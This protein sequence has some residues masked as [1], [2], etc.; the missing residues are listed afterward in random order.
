[1]ILFTL[2]GVSWLLAG[3]TAPPRVLLPDEQHAIDRK[4]VEY[5]GGYELRRFATG[6]TAPTCEAF[7]ADGSLL[8]AQGERGDEP[9]IWRFPRSG[10]APVLV[11]PRKPKFPFY[12][13]RGGWRMYGPIGGMVVADGKIIV[14]HRDEHDQGVV[15]ELDSAGNHTTLVAGMPAQGEYG[16]TDLAINPVTGDLWFG[17]GTYTNSGVVG[18]DDWAMRWVRDHPELH[19]V[20][21]HDIELLGYKFQTPNP[22]AG[23]FGPADLAV[24]AAFQAFSQS[25]AIRIPGSPDGRP[26]GAIYSVPR[27]G[28]FPQVQGHGI[29]NPSGIVFN[30]YAQAYFTNQGMEMR[31]TRPIKNDPC[32]LL[33]L[34]LDGN[35][36]FGWPDYTADLRSVGEPLYQPPEWMISRSGYPQVRPLIDQRASGLE[37]PRRDALLEAAFPSLSGAGKLAFYRGPNREYRDNLIVVL[38]GDRTPFASG[39][40]VLPRREGFKVVR[41]DLARHVTADFVRNVHDL[42]GSSIGHNPDLIERPFDV[43]F[44]PDGA[45]YILDEGRMQM[46]DGR[47]HFDKG[48]GQIFRLVPV[49][50]AATQGK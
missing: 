19:D 27:H 25:F 46:K 16:L 1:M 37:A 8:I 2:F 33:R 26:S 49:R 24:T 32:A 12:L 13:A 39:G 29:H 7:D 9:Q 18:I 48:S 23:L 44:G 36:W 45:M 31:G 28:G 41:V 6:L 4:D 11:Y 30:E 50:P 5:P 3:C 21:W 34:L 40:V 35:V 22:L 14:T 38:S 15:T 20:P 47:E 42:P 17:C 43:K 10:A